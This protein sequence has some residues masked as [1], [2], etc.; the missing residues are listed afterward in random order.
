MRFSQ[1]EH[2]WE[3]QLAEHGF[4]SPDRVVLPDERDGRGR[5]ATPMFRLWMDTQ[6]SR[7]RSPSQPDSL[8]R[9]HLEQVRTMLLT[10]TDLKEWHSPNSTSRLNEEKD[11]ASVIVSSS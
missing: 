7:S 8:I 5:E 10:Q 2:A 1:P 6:G 11:I 3:G 9:Q 4:A